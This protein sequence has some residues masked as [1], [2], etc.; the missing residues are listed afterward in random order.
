MKYLKVCFHRIT[1]VNRSFS[2][3]LA[4]SGAL[5]AGTLGIVP[6]AFSSIAMGGAITDG[7]YI[8]ESYYDGG[9]AMGAYT[10]PSGFDYTNGTLSQTNT[11]SDPGYPYA[12]AAATASL[13]NNQLSMSLSG[14]NT[15]TSGTA[16]MWDT[17]TLGNLPSGPTVTSSTVL[18]ILNMSIHASVGTATYGVDAQSGYGLNLYNTALF[19]PYVMGDCGAVANNG[20]CG[21]LLAQDGTPTGNFTPGT[22]SFSVPITFGGLTNGQIAYI[23]EIAA[24][25]TSDPSLSAPLVIDPAI[26]LTGLYPGVTVASLS[27]NNYLATVPLPGAAWL[28]GSG[29]LGM[30]GAALRKVD[31]VNR[32]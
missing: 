2:R 25:N 16:E 7:T 29:V 27:G 26:T 3:N 11:I 14:S 20:P 21:G 18:G 12:S 28:F 10:T 13:A 31:A 19:V 8:S 30:L 24:S 23:A 6:T 1:D 15:Y 9:M 17:L 22:Y 4:L 5:L 32:G